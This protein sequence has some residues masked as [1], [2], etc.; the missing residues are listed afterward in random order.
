M[1]V[2]LTAVIRNS[3]GSAP[4]AQVTEC[5]NAFNKFQLSCDDLYIFYVRPFIDNESRRG[6]KGRAG[7]PSE[8]VQAKHWFGGGGGGGDARSGRV[9]HPFRRRFL[10]H[11][12]GGRQQEKLA[13]LL[14]AQQTT[15]ES[16]KSSAVAPLPPVVKKETP[17][18]ET[19]TAESFL[20]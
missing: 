16:R 14:A 5:E 20:S 11:P 2:Q 9:P 13:A 17:H 7:L 8:H 15:E 18:T 19:F 6:G 12:C 10:T 4:P 3:S 1:V